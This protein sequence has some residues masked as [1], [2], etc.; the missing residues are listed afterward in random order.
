MG[1]VV[2]GGFDIGPIGPFNPQEPIVLDIRYNHRFRIKVVNAAN[3]IIANLKAKVSLDGVLQHESQT[4]QDGLVEL[5]CSV[6]ND[7][8]AVFRIELWY[9]SALSRRP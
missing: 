2:G 9:C 3:Q 6:L 1:G 4:S 7:A 5:S 8:N